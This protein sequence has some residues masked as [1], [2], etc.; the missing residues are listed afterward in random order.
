MVRHPNQTLEEQKTLYKNVALE[1]PSPA[2][3]NTQRLDIQRFIRVHYLVLALDV[4]DLVDR[5][6]FVTLQLMQSGER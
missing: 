1:Y 3:N 2:A 5:R 6:L 4:C